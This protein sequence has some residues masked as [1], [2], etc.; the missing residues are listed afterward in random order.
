MRLGGACKRSVRSNVLEALV[1]ASQA[2]LVLRQQQRKIERRQIV[3]DWL[4]LSAECLD[5]RGDELHVAEPLEHLL[6]DLLADSALGHLRD[7]VT[8]KG[9]VSLARELAQRSPGTGVH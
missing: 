7:A 8:D 2:A 4:G 5:H 9:F 1:G 6:R 3:A